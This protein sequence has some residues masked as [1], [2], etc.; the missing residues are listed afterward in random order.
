MNTNLLLISNVEENYWYQVLRDA[1]SPSWTIKI[2][3]ENTALDF[4]REN[5][6]DLVIIDATVVNDFTKL[7]FKIK[8]TF[9]D[10]NVVIAT[11]T[12]TWTRARDAFYAGAIDYIRKSSNKDELLY[13]LQAAL[14][15]AKQMNNSS[16]N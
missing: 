12:P 10:A 16:Q 15:K 2:S 7:I 6:F 8:Q 14:E 5:P 11:A 1:V 13:D 9:P 4:I 3:D